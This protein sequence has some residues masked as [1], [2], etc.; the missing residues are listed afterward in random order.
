MDFAVRFVARRLSDRNRGVQIELMQ[1]LQKVFSVLTSSI[2]ADVQLQPG[3][4]GRKLV[5]GAPEFLISFHRFGE[6]EGCGS[7]PFLL[8]EEGNMMCIASGIDPDSDMNVA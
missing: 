1:P 6:M 4:L 3:M 2:D 5:D 8:I 7:G